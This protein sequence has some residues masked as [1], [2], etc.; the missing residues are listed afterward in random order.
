[1]K[2]EW[3]EQA[4]LKDLSLVTASDFREYDLVIAGG[5]TVGADTWQEASKGNLWGVF[6]SQLE[7]GSLKGLNVALFGLG[8][9]VL[10][11]NHFV[12]SL[13]QLHREFTKAGA[14]LLGKWPAD[15]YKF[16]ASE[17]LVGNHFLGLALDEDWQADQTLSRIRTWTEQLKNEMA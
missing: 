5:S 15:G 17:A 2:A 8:D 4:D 12:D 16:T 9:Q 6:F 7:P 3:G 14:V 13:G 10:Y 11:P 1:M